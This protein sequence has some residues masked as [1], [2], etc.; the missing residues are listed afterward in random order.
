M[1][2][3]L[4]S[5][6]WYYIPGNFTAESRFYKELEQRACM[7]GELPYYTKITKQVINANFE[8]SR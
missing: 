7:R 1:P 5:A 8:N 3:L 2:I 6:I 4:W